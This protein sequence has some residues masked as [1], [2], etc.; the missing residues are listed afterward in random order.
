MK[1]LT[2]VLALSLLPPI[3]FGDENV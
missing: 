1:T 2:L 3:T